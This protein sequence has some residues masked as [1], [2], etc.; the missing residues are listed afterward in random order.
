MFL[1]YF[2]KKENKY[3]IIADN[4]YLNILSESKIFLK[5][6]FFLEKNFD[7]T[8][9]II[10][11]LLIFHIKSYKNDED[12]KNIFKQELI[13]NLINDLDLSIRDIGIGDMSISKYVKKYVKKFYYRVKVLDSILENNNILEDLKKYLYSLS[14]IE[15]KK[16]HEI[17]L[18][19]LSIYKKLNR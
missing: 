1:Q 18:K 13:N 11:I 6:R 19:L 17:S 3:K 10:S 16:V 4:T 12:V 15:H 14:L 9:E 5:E 8:F 2:K 7:S